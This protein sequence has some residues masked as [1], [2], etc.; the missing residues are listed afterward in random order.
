MVRLFYETVHTVNI[1]DYTLSQA[2]AW[3]PAQEN[4]ERWET[5]LESSETLV[6]LEGVRI[7]GFGS[8]IPSGYLDLLYVHKDF[9]RK[10]IAS[11]MADEIE[12]IAERYGRG[13]IFTEASVTA[14]PFFESRGYAVV[15]QQQKPLNGEI[16]RNYIMKKVLK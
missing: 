16:F 14:K 3:A 5:K 12:L 13:E 2:D 4:R 7:V 11:S 10:G 6:T 8:F 15:K 1:R 9:Q